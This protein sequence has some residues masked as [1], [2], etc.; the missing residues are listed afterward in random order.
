M[1]GTFTQIY[2]LAVFAVKG[3]SHLLQKPWRD[4]ARPRSVPMSTGYTPGVARLGI[5]E[6]ERDDA[7]IGVTN[8]G[9]RRCDEGTTVLPASIAVGASFKPRLAR[10]PP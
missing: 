6:L 3:R 10:G 2:L 5:P 9:Y 8:P 1:T 4:K 7:S